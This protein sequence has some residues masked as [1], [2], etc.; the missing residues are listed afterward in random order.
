MLVGGSL[1]NYLQ[2]LVRILLF[3]ALMYVREYTLFGPWYAMP[4]IDAFAIILLWIRRQKFWWQE[5]NLFV[6]K[7]NIFVEIPFH[8]QNILTL[9][10]GR[11]PNDCH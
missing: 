10:F 7:N 2:S 11:C 4:C 9:E 6:L 8:I 1:L 3:I 5:W